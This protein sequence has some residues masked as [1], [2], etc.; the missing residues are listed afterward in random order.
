L[1]MLAEALEIDML[2]KSAI[3]RGIRARNQVL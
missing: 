1:E 3:E 2:T